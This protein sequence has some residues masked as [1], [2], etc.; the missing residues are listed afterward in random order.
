MAETLMDKGFQ[1]NCTKS[2]K[3][4]KTI[5]RKHAMNKIQMAETYVNTICPANLSNEDLFVS[6]KFS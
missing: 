2:E 1:R 6:K 5:N 3:S 4:C